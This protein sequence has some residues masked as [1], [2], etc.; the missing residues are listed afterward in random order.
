MSAFDRLHE[1]VRRWI[2]QQGWEGLREIQER[3]IP[4]LLQGQRDLIIMAATA[5]GKTEAAFLPIV[6]RLAEQPPGPADGFQAIYVS[7]MRALIND[8]FG[9]IESL[10]KDLDISVTKWHGDV[11]ASLKARARQNPTGILLITPES[12][13]ALLVR[14]GKEVGRI[15]RGLRYVVIDE[16][17]A[18]LEDPRGK[19]LQSVL[20]RIDLASSSRPVRVGLSATLGD[21]AAARGFLRPLAPDR[22][23]LLPPTGKMAPV[24]LQVRGYV[25]ATRL[26]PTKRNQDEEET[27]DTEEASADGALVRDLFEKH[28]LTRSLIFA[29]S[30]QN[31]EKI[32]VTLS[33]MTEAQGVPDGFVA[34]HGN[35]SREHREEAEQ[36]MKDRSRPASIICT[37]TLELGIDVGDIEAVAQ[38]GP[39]HTVSGMR[40]RLGRSGRRPGQA[41]IM[42]IYVTETELDKDTSALDALRTRTVQSIAMV[43][44]MARRW[45]E[46]P[47]PDRLHLST[48]LHQIM[49]LVAQ[50]GGATPTE[51]WAYLVQ[52]SVFTGIDKE[53]LKTLLRHM[54]DPKVGLLERA[55]DGTLLPGPNGERLIESR[56]IFSV[57][58]SE[59]EYRVVARGGRTIGQIPSGDPLVPGQLLILAGRRWRILEVD[60]KR[61]EVTVQPAQGGRP[62]VF[63]GDPV[64]PADGVLDE[65]R[66]IYLDLGMPRYLDATA[67]QLLIEARTTFDRLGLRHSNVVRHD[68]QLLLFPWVG[69]RR[70]QAL[71]LALQAAD[72]EPVGLGL[73][74]AV[75]AERE[76]VLVRELDR[77]I[78][79]ATPDPHELARLVENKVIEKFDAFL[80]ESL[81]EMAWARDQLDFTPI[82]TIASALLDSIKI[83]PAIQSGSKSILY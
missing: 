49:A 66:K 38:I 60:D 3:S 82:S 79:G 6:S 14:R 75:P 11:S 51:L 26:R 8:Q 22:V 58:V 59:E 42:R 68:G 31:V 41:A 40:Q 63:K 48:L 70:R 12:L 29:G 19:Q 24:R 62:P 72:L 46:P 20:H 35:L 25:K 5:G 53:T 47:E 65:M 10:C 27:Q 50:L 67:Q 30:R 45:N 16:M 74:I 78:V 52:S 18:F 56:D 39:G 77:M 34:H 23:D 76:A 37:T 71:L 1:K 61:K 36:R 13:E 54:L 43:D 44:L 73:A 15:F 83:V 81:L 55:R 9:R 32:A 57:F 4:V 80:G 2:W 33:E 7:P 17:H 69:R 64:P 21:E 28:R